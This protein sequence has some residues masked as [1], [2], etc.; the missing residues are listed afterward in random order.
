MAAKHSPTEYRFDLIGVVSL[1]ARLDYDQAEAERTKI[2]NVLRGEEFQAELAR[3]VARAAVGAGVAKG[4][5]EALQAHVEL[6]RETLDRIDDDLLDQQ[7]HV[8]IPKSQ[9]SPVIEH[10][11]NQ[12]LRRLSVVWEGRHGRK[13]KVYAGVSRENYALVYN[14]PDPW[15]RLNAWSMG[16]TIF[17][18]E[19]DTGIYE[20][21]ATPRAAAE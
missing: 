6:T 20:E 9:H 15:V 17:M 5:I 14:D 13:R 7:I 3:L 8:T 4:T 11:Y 12:R 2:I 19:G 1:G 21:S 10:T 18:H 16:N